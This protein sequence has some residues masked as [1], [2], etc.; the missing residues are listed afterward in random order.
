MLPVAAST[1]T[2]MHT[3]CHNNVIVGSTWNQHV[4]LEILNNMVCG[5]HGLEHLENL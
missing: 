4:P 1:N 2:C 5:L 3:N